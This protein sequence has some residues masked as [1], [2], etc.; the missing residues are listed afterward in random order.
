MK[1][2]YSIKLVSGGGGNIYVKNFKKD[3][4]NLNGFAY[5]DWYIQYVFPKFRYFYNDGIFIKVCGE[6]SKNDVITYITKCYRSMSEDDFE[7]CKK[8]IENV[9]VFP[10]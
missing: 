6:V 10:K 1:A 9:L 7:M 8:V 2:K 3:G 5:K 4:K